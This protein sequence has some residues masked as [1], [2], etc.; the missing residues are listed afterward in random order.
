[1]A[2]YTLHKSNQ[3][4]I[5]TSDEEIKKSNLYYLPRTNSVYKCEEGPTLWEK[6]DLIKYPGEYNEQQV[7]WLKAFFDTHKWI[8]RMMIV[9][10]D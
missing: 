6:S 3:D 2:K 9:F 10:N 7:Y 5:L 8:N 1:M 4:F